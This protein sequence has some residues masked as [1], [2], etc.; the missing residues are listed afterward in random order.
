MNYTRSLYA[1]IFIILLSTGPLYGFDELRLLIPEFRPYTY[2]GNGSVQGSGMESLQKVLKESGVPYSSV[3][4]SSHDMA[5]SETRSGNAD[6]FF[7]ASARLD[8]DSFAVFSGAILFHRWT[9]FL[10]AGSTYNP[11]KASF[12]PYARVGTIQHSSM[13]DWLQK[14]GY[15]ISDMP[16][17]ADSLIPMLKRGTINVI[18]M[19]ETEFLQAIEA[20]GEKPDRYKMVVQFETPL[21]LYVSKAYL[22]K[23]PGA[24][25]KISKAVEN[26]VDGK[27][28]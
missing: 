1:I 19:P 22:E 16:R 6:A 3:V 7:P 27:G 12:K 2:E 13:Y 21:G 28:N 14:N 5:V 17:S 24:M 15:R 4:V 26:L 8:R 11:A 9:W 10:P 20:A 18:L 25:E 23:N